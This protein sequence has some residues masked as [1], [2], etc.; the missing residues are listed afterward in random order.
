MSSGAYY[1]YEQYI[2][3]NQKLQLQLLKR[4]HQVDRQWYESV[5]KII[6]L[7]GSSHHVKEA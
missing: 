3:E 1:C 6:V 2:P 7:T 5:L 4:V